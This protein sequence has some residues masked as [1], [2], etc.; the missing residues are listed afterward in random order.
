MGYRRSY[1]R[2]KQP[3]VEDTLWAS[4][5]YVLF[6][7]FF[8]LLYRFGIVLVATILALLLCL[9]AGLRYRWL[10]SLLHL[11]AGSVDRPTS[12]GNLPSA[13]LGRAQ[14]QSRTAYGQGY[15]PQTSQQSP[16][17]TR[18]IGQQPK[19]DHPADYEQP[20]AQYPDQKPPLP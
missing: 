4:L 17:D 10:A 12:A 2:R 1:G 20:Q 5:A 14:E 13:A 18:N 9:L 11:P 15:R 3:S 7:V 8:F 16:R 19:Q 6:I